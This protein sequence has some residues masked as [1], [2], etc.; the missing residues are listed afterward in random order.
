MRENADQSNSAYEHF[1]DSESLSVE[2]RINQP[3]EIVPKAVLNYLSYL[4]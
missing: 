2:K 4:S 1:S 3:K